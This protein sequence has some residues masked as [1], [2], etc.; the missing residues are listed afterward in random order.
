MRMVK[1]QEFQ[2]HPSQGILFSPIEGNFQQFE[3]LVKDYITPSSRTIRSAK[4]LAEI[5]ASK[6]R[7][8]RDNSLAAI[9]ENK[10]SEIIL[11]TLHLRKY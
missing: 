1:L 10:N 2:L 9:R 5:M 7:L 8:L 11:S 3:N 6:A 4:K